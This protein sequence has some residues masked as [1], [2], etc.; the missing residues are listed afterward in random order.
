MPN[1]A[2]LRNARA[3]R[4]TRKSVREWAGVSA[5]RSASGAGLVVRPSADCRGLGGGLFGWGLQDD[6]LAG[7]VFELADEVALPALLADL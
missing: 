3:H 4:L 1:D 5:R 7:E 2:V 6:L